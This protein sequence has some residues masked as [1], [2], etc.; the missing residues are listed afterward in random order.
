MASFGNKEKGQLTCEKAAKT[1]EEQF[2]ALM[3]DASIYARVLVLESGRD[4]GLPLSIVEGARV[5]T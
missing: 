5:R 1:D 4:V 2:E 3:P